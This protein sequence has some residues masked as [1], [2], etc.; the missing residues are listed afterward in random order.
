MSSWNLEGLRVVG[1]YL[2]GDVRV[3]GVVTLSRVAYGGMITHHVKLDHGFTALKGAVSRKAGETVI[4][5]NPYI[6]QV[7]SGN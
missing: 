7:L 4:L 6:Y 3:T 1:G 2:Q 5:D